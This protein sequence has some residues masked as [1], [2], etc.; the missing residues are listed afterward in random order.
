VEAVACAAIDDMLAKRRPYWQAG[1]LVVRRLRQH[2]LE[3][4]PDV[5]VRAARAAV[6][7]AAEVV[8]GIKYRGVIEYPLDAD[9]L[10]IEMEAVWSKIKFVDS[11]VV[12]TMARLAR[13]RPGTF[14]VT[15]PDPIRLLVGTL[16]HLSQLGGRG[17]AS[18]SQASLAEALGR[19]PRMVSR[20]LRA[21]EQYGFI[22]CV[23]PK[24]IPGRKAMTWKVLVGPKYTPP[25]ADE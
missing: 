22:T 21:A 3:P 11:N 9:D 1:F 5:L 4:E 20:Y 24:F 8:V 2:G 18:P 25:E 14:H 19:E 16:W 7:H 12:L 6:E 23:D 10:A 15:V 17:V 13:E